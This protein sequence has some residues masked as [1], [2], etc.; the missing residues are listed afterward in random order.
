MSKKMLVNAAHE[1]EV[2][3]AIIEDGV[4]ED[5]NVDIAG[6]EQIRGNVYKAR[7][8]SVESGL[9]EA[10]VDYGADRNGFV[11]FGD[12]LPRYYSRKPGKAEAK[13]EKAKIQD[14]LD[15]GTELLVQAYREEV[16]NKGAALT[17]EITLPGR[18]LVLMP[19]SASG[20]VS[21]KISD[22][23]TR[24][25]LKAVIDKLGPPAEMGVIV[26]TAGQGR[27][28][29]EFQKDYQELMR[30]W[31]HIQHKAAGARDLG[32]VYQEPNIVIRSVRDYF[33]DD[34]DEVISDDPG[35]HAAILDF[36]ER[37]MGGGQ[38]RVKHYTGKMPL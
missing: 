26:R 32:L 27:S 15:V 24:E 14:V 1:G 38:E 4:L 29:A 31:G 16:G 6:N 34:I 12:I 22:E 2:R 21:S 37:H 11:T 3:V 28:Q 23:R 18:Y 35:V 7:V 17:T 33:T 20:G 25:E 13:G 36:F 9:Q 5:L 10:F 8:V 30:I 19:F